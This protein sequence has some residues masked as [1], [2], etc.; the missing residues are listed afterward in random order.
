MGATHVTTTVRNPALT[1]L[2]S[3]RTEVD[4]RTQ[5]LKRRSAVRLKRSTMREF[6]K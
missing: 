5:H 3:V 4:P 1:A 2:Q 6:R